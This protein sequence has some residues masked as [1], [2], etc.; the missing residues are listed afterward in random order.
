MKSDIGKVFASSVPAA[1]A[2]LLV[3]S[4]CGPCPCC[5]RETEGSAEDAAV[6]LAESTLQ[7]GRALQAGGRTDEAL[8]LYEL[9]VRALIDGLAA[10]SDVRAK[11]AWA[12][13]AAGR[14]RDRRQAVSILEN[15]LV[16][17]TA[18]LRRQ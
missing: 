15:S 6:A 12:L 13:R 4:G 5:P 3:L 16:E 17:A 9:R 18:V 2:G 1:L 10:R 14:A 7:R 11:L 8:D